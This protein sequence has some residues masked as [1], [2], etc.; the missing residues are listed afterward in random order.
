MTSGQTAFL[1]KES[2]ASGD[3][4]ECSVG[5]LPPGAEALI[6]FAYVTELL[7]EGDGAVRFTYPAV[8]GDR[9]GAPDKPLLT[10]NTS[11]TPSVYIKVPLIWISSS[12]ITY[13]ALAH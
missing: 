7:V 4:F 5:N 13:R 3:V 10:G 2:S 1:L 9:Y 8:L 11:T 12:L 6:R